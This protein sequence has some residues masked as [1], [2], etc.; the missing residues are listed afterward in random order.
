MKTK[1]GWL[2]RKARS[3]SLTVSVVCTGLGA[4]CAGLFAATAIYEKADVATMSRSLMSALLFA[5]FAVVYG[6]VAVRRSRLELKAG[7]EVGENRAEGS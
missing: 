1:M 7:G 3:H 4:F 6:F 2:D 5:T